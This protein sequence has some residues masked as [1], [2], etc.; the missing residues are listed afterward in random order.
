MEV[1]IDNRDG[2]VYEMPVRSVTWKTERIGKASELE[3]ELIIEDPLKYSIK[4]G[5]I[6]RVMDGKEKVFYGYVFKV[7]KGKNDTVKVTAFDQ[8]RYLMYNDTF[9]IKKMT[10]TAAIT[11]ILKDFGLKIGK[12]ANTGTILPGIVEDD[13][14][15]FDVVVQ[16]LDSNLVASNKNYV[17]FDNFGAIDLAKI[18]DLKIPPEDFYIGENSLLYDYE[19][20]ASIDGDTFNRIKLVHDNEKTS[21]R[22]VYIAQ[23]SG[24][25]AKWGKLQKFRKV[26]KN[27]KPAQIKELANNLLALHNREEETLELSCLG[28]WR[29]RAGRFLYFRIDKFGLNR[30]Y[31]VDECSHEWTEGVH[32]MSLKVKVI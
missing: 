26:D 22:E 4:S 13:K 25:I 31:L 3:T 18:D 32:T 24:N 23:D 30:Y 8:L 29:V 28:D 16:Y 2:K 17:I 10:A 27:M 7:G 21:K 12:L 11:K 5:A 6:V 19:Y 1:L 9:V 15:A 14:K 20:E